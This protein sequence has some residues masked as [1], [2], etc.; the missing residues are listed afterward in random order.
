MTLRKKLLIS[1]SIVNICLLIVASLGIGSLMKTN[2][3]YENI[4]EKRVDILFEMHQLIEIVYDE[5]KT[6]RGYF[7]Y[8]D[9]MYMDDFYKLTKEFEKTSDEILKNATNEDIKQIMYEIIDLHNQYNKEIEDAVN[10]MNNGTMTREQALEEVKQ[11]GEI[12]IEFAAKA[13]KAVQLQTDLVKQDRDNV[14]KSSQTTL[15][16]IIV[17]T[18]LAAIVAIVI[19]FT[20]SRSITVP[21]NRLRENADQTADGNL[22]SEDL[23]ATTKDEIAAL[24]KSFNSMKHNLRT[25]L[26]NIQMMAHRV[27]NATGQLATSGE[28]TVKASNDMATQIQDIAEHAEQSSYTTK[29]AASAMEE[30]AVAVQRIAE[31]TSE[32]S[33]ISADT[34]RESVDG[35]AAVDSAIQQM[36]SI[37][38]TVGQ[39]AQVISHL[40]ERSSQI[41]EITEVISAISAQTNLLSLNAAIEAARAGEQGKG[42]AVVAEEI[43]KLAEQSS[44]STEEIA[45]LI[46]EIQLET[47]NAVQAMEQGT[48]EVE[49][50]VTV[51][52][53]A[54]GSFSQ[55]N[56][57]IQKVASQIEEVSAASEELSASVEEVTASV[58]DVAAQA[59]DVSNATQ[60]VAAGSEELL[61]TM[62]EVEKRLE[63]LNG[64]VREMNQETDRFTL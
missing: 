46:S 41:G 30:M 16:A 34:A 52:E 64:I 23:Q 53:H 25:V 48:N 54:G 5:Q 55:I 2:K 27:G 15:V 61:A 33:D 39:L 24:V 21:I 26:T 59:G 28:E 62:E 6:N 19:A 44:R 58:Q 20:T 10:A 11:A 29:E 38:L 42:F 60:S 50:G 14:T 31:N 13:D 8:N 45:K 43:R 17:V 37:Q 51:V 7:L 9:Q 3:A 1:F 49:K 12:G 4:L 35:R 40:N 56:G 22:T 57:L 47:S 32:I 63:E 18:V 36:Q